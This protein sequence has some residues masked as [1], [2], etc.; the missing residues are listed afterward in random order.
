MLASTHL[1]G[2]R[3]GLLTSIKFAGPRLLAAVRKEL[4]LL[5]Q[6]LLDG[7]DNHSLVLYEAVRRKVAVQKIQRNWRHRI[8]VRGSDR[9]C[10]HDRVAADN[11]PSPPHRRPRQWASLSPCSSTCVEATPWVA[12]TSGPGES[13]SHLSRYRYV[14]QHPDEAEACNI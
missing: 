9:L 14:R 12:A 6:V 1:L 8:K 5:G 10:G 4:E 2:D 3:L 11:A 13:A 7:C